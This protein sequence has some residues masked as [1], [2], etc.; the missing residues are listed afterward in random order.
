MEVALNPLLRQEVSYVAAPPLL[1]EYS[2]QLVG[3]FPER[4]PIYAPRLQLFDPIR[5]P[6]SYLDHQVKR[7]SAVRNNYIRPA[8]TYAK[9]H[10]N[11]VIDSWTEVVLVHI[12]DPTQ[13]DQ[14]KFPKT[15]AS[16]YCAC[17]DWVDDPKLDSVGRFNQSIIQLTANRLVGLEMLGNRHPAL[18]LN[19]CSVCGSPLR[20]DCCPSC[21]LHF[22]CRNDMAHIGLDLPQKVRSLLTENGHIFTR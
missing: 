6:C 12:V 3:Y 20:S 13:L 17:N 19:Y 21:D 11:L 2:A 22:S 8:F 5:L 4:P 9:R 7:H 16:V 1:I 18:T 10:W 14:G 15:I